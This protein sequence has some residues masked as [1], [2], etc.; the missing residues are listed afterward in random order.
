MKL[1]PQPQV[2]V[3][4]AKLHG[5]FDVGKRLIWA[6][7]QRFDIAPPRIGSRKIAIERNRGFE[8]FKRFFGLFQG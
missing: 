8:C 6:V 5:A 2:G 1:E 4:T 3:A 7:Q